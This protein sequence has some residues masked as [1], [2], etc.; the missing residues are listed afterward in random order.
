MATATDSIIYKSDVY[1]ASNLP[2]D[3]W[4]S[5]SPTFNSSKKKRRGD[6]EA[7]EEKWGKRAVLIL[8]GVRLGLDG[9]NPIYYDSIKVSF[10]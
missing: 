7:K 5:I 3:N 10:Y 4:N 2:S 9:V 8:V 1:T 6:N